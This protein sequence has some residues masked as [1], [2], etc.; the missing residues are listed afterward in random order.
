MLSSIKSN[1]TSSVSIFNDSA[2]YSCT[3]LNAAKVAYLAKEFAFGGG[4]DTEMLTVPGKMGNDGEHA[5]Y[6]IDDTAFFEQ[7]LSVYYERV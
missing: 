1:I 6:K 3:N 2:P 5:E 7:F 4:M